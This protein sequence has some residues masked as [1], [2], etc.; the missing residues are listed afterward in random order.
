MMYIHSNNEINNS[1]PVLHWVTM[2]HWQSVVN[3]GENGA[4]C[5]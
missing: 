2:Q 1:D 4:K 3:S 5:H